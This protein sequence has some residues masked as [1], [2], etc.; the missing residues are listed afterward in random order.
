MKRFAAGSALFAA[1]VLLAAPARAGVMEEKKK[2][3]A[4]MEAALKEP[5]AVKSSSGLVF[6]T[7]T[8]GSGESPKATDTVKVNYEGKFID[9]KVF[10]SSYQGGQPIE[11]PLNKVI[12]CWTEGVQKMKVGETAQLICPPG[13]AYGDRGMGGVVPPGATLVFKV[14]LLQIVK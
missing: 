13:I 11:F 14:E 4:F 2:T 5:G 10:D 6:R 7:L 8:P 12:K 9:G 3:E 1:A